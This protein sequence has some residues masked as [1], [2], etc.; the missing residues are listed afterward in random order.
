MRKFHTSSFLPFNQVISLL[1]VLLACTLCASPA[2]AASNIVAWGG[3]TFTD[4]NSYYNWGQSIVP[5]G[6]S[7]A[8]WVAGGWRHSLAVTASNTPTSW[9]DDSLGQ[10]DFTVQTNFSAVACGWQHSLAL[11]TN[12][13]V[14]AA[15]DD[16]ILQTNLPPGLSNVVAISC[17]FYHSLALKSD[18]TVAAWG[19]GTNLGGVGTDPNYGQT[20]V[21]AG[22][23]NVVAIAGGG[24][25][26]LALLSDGTVQAWGYNSNGQTNVPAGLTNATAIAAGAA[27]SLALL[28]D[29]TVRA[30]G[31]DQYNQ[32]SIPAGLSNVVAIAAGGWHS[33]ALK[34]DG[35]VVAWGAS[36]PNAS[37]N[38]IGWGQQL[39][40]GGLTN[41]QQIAGGAVHSLALTGSNLPVTQI[42]L[43]NY[44]LTSNGFSI[45][46]PTRNG[47]VYRLEY[48][49]SLAAGSWTALPLRAGTGKLLPF[50]D[51]AAPPGGQ[52]FYRIRRW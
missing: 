22:L 26:S 7:N 36:G 27:F 45:S 3:G 23:S 47:R 10:T 11:L 46:L 41:V 48:R 33:L 24:W 32:I 28:A 51:P 52:R 8:V 15:G 2:G 19:G 39:V 18:G 17:G 29:G 38:N 4:Q 25:H 30:W 21:P 44:S 35:T 34:S 49:D 12:G 31:D 13:I 16:S 50:I 37:T 20:D 6:L 14:A 9:G 43:T 42:F 5:A 1:G 40:P